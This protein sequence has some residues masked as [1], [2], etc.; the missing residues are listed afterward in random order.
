MKAKTQGWGT[1]CTGEAF[2]IRRE[3][4]DVEEAAEEEDVEEAAVAVD[5]SASRG[6]T[7]AFVGLE[8]VANFVM[9]VQVEVLARQ[10][11][12][13]RV[14]CKGSR[15]PMMTWFVSSSI[16]RFFPTRRLEQRLSIPP[17]CGVAV[18]CNTILWT[19]PQGA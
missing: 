3:A 17:A 10:A 13:S 16:C 1:S 7:L 9:V 5:Q 18:G 8:V 11:P 15:G 6:V 2:D 14:R 4:V 12:G 19:V